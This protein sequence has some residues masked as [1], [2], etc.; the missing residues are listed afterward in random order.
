MKYT[1]ANAR[2][3]LVIPVLFSLFISCS[4][5]DKSLQL[6]SKD[7]LNTIELSLNEK[8]SLYYQVKRRDSVIIGSSPL[9]LKCN[10]QDFTQELSITEIS[11]VGEKREQYQLKVSNNKQTDQLFTTKSVTLKNSTGALLVVDLVS[12]AE[13]VAFR[14]RFPEQENNLRTIEEEITGFQIE[15]NAK[16]W[17]QPYKMQ[18]LS[19][20][21]MKIFILM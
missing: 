6:T 16:G 8:G 3:F 7:G 5:E 1:F 17:L 9:G 11:P 19:P 20:R 10:D 21:G 15:K 14:Y 13:G 2:M 18:A 12:G 4:G